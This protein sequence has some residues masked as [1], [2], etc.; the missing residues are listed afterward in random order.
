M[1]GWQDSIYWLAKML[2]DEAYLFHT[3]PLISG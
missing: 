3:Y 1:G 2:L